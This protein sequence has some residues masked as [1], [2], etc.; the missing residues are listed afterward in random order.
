MARPAATILLESVDERNFETIHILE[1]QA[2]FTVMYCGKPFNLRKV[3]VKPNGT[4]KYI[5]TSF[6][7]PG[8]AIN[9][10]KKLNKRFKTTD[11]KV[12][13]STGGNLYDP[14]E[15]S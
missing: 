14:E 4:I 11:F 7:N 8:H 3:S 5:K 1:A 15:Q 6:V 10:A 2:L 13:S 12:Y 9:L